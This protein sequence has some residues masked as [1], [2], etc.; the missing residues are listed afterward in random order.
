MTPPGVLAARLLAVTDHFVGTTTPTSGG[1]VTNRRVIPL[2]YGAASGWRM[3]WKINPAAPT[4]STLK[5]KIEG[6]PTL[7]FGGAASVLL[8]PGEWIES[9]PI[10]HQVQTG[11]SVTIRQTITGAGAVPTTGRGTVQDGVEAWAWGDLYDGTGQTGMIVTGNGPGMH[12]SLVVGTPLVDK[13]ALIVCGDS[14]IAGPTSFVEQAGRTAGV[15]MMSFGTGGEGSGNGFRSNLAARMATVGAGQVQ[16]ALHQIA[17]NDSGLGW[18]ECGRQLVLDWQA[19]RSYGLPP[20]QLTCT[21]NTTSTDGWAT[22]ANQTPGSLSAA[23]VALNGWLRDGAPLYQGAPVTSGETG[24]GSAVRAGQDGHP[25]K[26]IWDTAAAIQDTANP[27]LARVG[28]YTGT[29]GVHPGTQGHLW[30]A[31]D[32]APRLATYRDDAPPA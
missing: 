8:V 23:I 5:I 20:I 24:Y 3:R 25:C 30:L 9:D 13:P 2:P 31:A 21:P 17:I 29:D 4:G 1:A 28:A 19:Y 27:A 7:T 18:P 16:A 26:A 14:I 6:G 10:A 22:T 12:P 11:G 15:P 32:L